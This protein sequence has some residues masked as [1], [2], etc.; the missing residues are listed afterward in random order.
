MKMWSFWESKSLLSVADLVYFKRVQIGCNGW[1]GSLFWD[2]Q[3]WHL[4]NLQP[5]DLERFKE[6]TLLVRSKPKII[7]L[8]Q[9]T[10]IVLKISFISKNWPHFHSVYLLACVRKS[11]SMTEWGTVTI[12][13]DKGLV[14][15]DFYFFSTSSLKIEFVGKN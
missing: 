7:L 6:A 12:Y 15:I 11:Q 5:F 9:E 14:S 2:L 3:F 1:N 8:V 13:V 10:S 4:V